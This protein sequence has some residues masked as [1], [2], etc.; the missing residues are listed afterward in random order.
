MREGKTMVRTIGREG[1]W[2]SAPWFQ[3]MVLAPNMQKTVIPDQKSLSLL[4][5]REAVS[6]NDDEMIFHIPRTKALHTS[7]LTM[8]SPKLRPTLR[9]L[10]KPIRPSLPGRDGPCLLYTSPSPRD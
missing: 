3:N 2:F 9:S 4:Y 8:K 10:L 7:S 5:T 6:Q 1:P